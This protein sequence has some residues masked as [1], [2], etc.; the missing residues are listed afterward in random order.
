MKE[1]GLVPGLGIVGFVRRKADGL[2]L[3]LGAEI[4]L[5]QVKYEGQASNFD[6]E[7]VP[8]EVS[9]ISDKF[10][11]VG[12]TGGPSL[13]MSDRGT[14]TPYAG[15][16]IRWWSD[17][18]QKSPGGY[19]RQSRYFY[20]PIGLMFELGEWNEQ[21]FEFVLEYDLFWKGRQKSR[22]SDASG[23]SPDGTQWVRYTDITNY[24]SSGSGLRAS[25]SYLSKP[26]FLGSPKL[27]WAIRGFVRYWDIDDSD[28]VSSKVD[29]NIGDPDW[30]GIWL[31]DF[32]EPANNTLQFGMVVMLLR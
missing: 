18:A 30:D 17:A 19:F 32:I 21:Q 28:I 5:S 11:E 20:S 12:F 29:I 13:R 7:I 1:T 27:R 22:L 2:M 10:Y 15:L 8:L 3:S 16:G 24:Q 6:G 26:S 25:A 4:A 23:E 9:G 14:M 31:V